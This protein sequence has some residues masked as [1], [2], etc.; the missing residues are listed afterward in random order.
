LGEGKHEEALGLSVT[1]LDT[2]GDALQSANT[3]G[4]PTVIV[5]A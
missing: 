4:A 1:G 3:S 2:T 5:D